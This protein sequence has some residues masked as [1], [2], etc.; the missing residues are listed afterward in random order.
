MHIR[1]F[2]DYLENFL[3][4]EAPT[5]FLTTHQVSLVELIKLLDSKMTV[6]SLIKR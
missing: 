1:A 2:R 6:S 3:L 5:T 4:S